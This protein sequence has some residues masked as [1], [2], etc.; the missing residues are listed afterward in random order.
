MSCVRLSEGLAHWECSG[1]V[2]GAAFAL[3]T[4]L[5]THFLAYK[6][7]KCGLADVFA[8]RSVISRVTNQTCRIQGQS[9]A[10]LGFL[11]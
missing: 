5:R 9:S 8:S 10:V 6:S 11:G 4:L 1:T 7:E 2:A 3:E